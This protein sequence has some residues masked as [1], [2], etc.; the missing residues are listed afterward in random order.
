MIYTHTEVSERLRE[1]RLKRR[2]SNVNAM[3]KR[4]KIQDSYHTRDLVESIG[5]GLAYAGTTIDISKS[6]N[7][8]L[9]FYL[10]Q[11]KLSYA[12]AQKVIET[13]ETKGVITA[14]D[15]LERDI[16]KIR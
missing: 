8:L 3:Y 14:V 1:F 11:G 12:Q 4:A 16:L 10:T 6:V 9:G 15:C 13:E 2:I 5:N 7:G